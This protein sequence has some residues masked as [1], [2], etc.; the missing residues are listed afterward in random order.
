VSFP[1]VLGGLPPGSV[2][3][4][5]GDSLRIRPLLRA[6]LLTCP[7]IAGTGLAHRAGL[8]RSLSARW[9]DPSQMCH[10][11]TPPRSVPTSAPDPG[12]RHE[13]L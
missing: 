12:R 11:V 10:P 5:L 13:A 8:I 1:A 7:Q 3:V 4:I 9:R 2:S 6:L